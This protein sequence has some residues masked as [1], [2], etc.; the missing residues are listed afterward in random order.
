MLKRK[1]KIFQFLFVYLIFAIILTLV[2]F[3]YAILIHNDIISLTNNSFKN[4]SFIIGIILF[5]ILGLI[6]GIIA[7]KNGLVEGLLS[8]LIILSISILI[9]LILKVELKSLYFIKIIAYLISAMAG[10]I[11]GVNIVNKN[12]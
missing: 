11:I 9:N 6:S 10:G 12:K 7:K 8:A 2:A 1:N 3:I 4:I 5:L